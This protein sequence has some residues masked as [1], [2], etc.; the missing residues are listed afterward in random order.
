MKK[1]VAILLLIASPAF[2]DTAVIFN[3]FGNNVAGPAPISLTMAMNM[4]AD[5]NVLMMALANDPA[6]VKTVT[7][8]G[9]GKVLTTCQV[10][11]CRYVWPRTAMRSGSNTV[12]LQYVNSAGVQ[13]QANGYV[14]KP[15]AL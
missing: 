7:I 11:S 8:L 14:N 4:D 9:N 10:A 12:V 13:R 3:T 15:G 6:G 5:H 2:A 1:L